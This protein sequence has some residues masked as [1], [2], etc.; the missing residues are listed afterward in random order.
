LIFD[1]FEKCLELH[2]TGVLAK[3]IMIGQSNQPCSIQPDDFTDC[4]HLGLV[5]ATLLGLFRMLL[6]FFHFYGQ[7]K[8]DSQLSYVQDCHQV[9]SKPTL[10]QVKKM[11]IIIP[12]TLTSINSNISKRH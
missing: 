7:L 11:Y 5:L 3:P 9:F 10:V 6:H 1:A 12:D 8:E 4:H 2:S